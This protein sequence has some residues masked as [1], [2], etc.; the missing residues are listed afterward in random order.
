MRLC[1]GGGRGKG[2]GEEEEKTDEEGDALDWMDAEEKLRKL[3]RRK[4]LKKEEEG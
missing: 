3:Q 4:R 2:G 1:C